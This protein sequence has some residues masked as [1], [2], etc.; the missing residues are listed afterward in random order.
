[1]RKRYHTKYKKRA[2]WLL[3]EKNKIAGKNKWRIAAKVKNRIIFDIDDNN[4][5]N[6]KSIKTYYEKLFKIEFILI[7]TKNGYHIISSIK[8]NDVNTWLYNVCRVLC[9]LL[10]EKDVLDY[11]IEINKLYNNIYNKN[12]KKEYIQKINTEL[13]QSGLDYHHGNFD[14]LFAINV[15]RKGFYCIRISKKS[16]DDYPIKVEI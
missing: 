2:F 13:A 1:M 15:I 9:P 7:K 3:N 16:E 11:Q 14:L 4:I 10:L 5:E 12:G 8:Y 6:I